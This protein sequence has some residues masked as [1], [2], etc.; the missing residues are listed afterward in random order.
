MVQRESPELN[1]KKIKELVVDHTTLNMD[2]AAKIR[3]D[4]P[5]ISPTAGKEA[6]NSETI[7]HAHRFNP[8]A[9]DLYNQRS[10][11]EMLS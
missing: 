4:K 10:L 8:T 1:I 5:F 7:L 3:K 2:A 6:L 9:L 11:C